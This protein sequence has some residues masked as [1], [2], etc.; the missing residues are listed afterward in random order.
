MK[1]YFDG[2][3]FTKGTELFKQ[4]DTRFSRLICDALGAEE[5]NIA[6]S[7]CSNHAIVRRLIL[8]N[9]ISDF[10]YAVIQMALP[11]RGEYY[12]GQRYRFL[13]PNSQQGRGEF[14]KWL[15]YYYQNIYHDKYG[16]DDECILY[17]TIKNH[18]EVNNVPVI[19]LTNRTFGTWQAKNKGKYRV[20]NSLVEF[21][22]NL[23]HYPKAPWRGH[24][25][26]EGHKMIAEDILSLLTKHK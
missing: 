5:Y 6:V 12:D 4:K 19:I 11:M 25:D 17:H 13:R 24:P 20:I 22:L 1:I 8:E 16:N 26:E 9:N 10:D 15:W 14:K 21:D 3:S 7:S 2:D 18:C 23:E